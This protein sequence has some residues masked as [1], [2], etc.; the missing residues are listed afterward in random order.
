MV[1]VSMDID[2]LLNSLPNTALPN[3]ALPNIGDYNNKSD[4]LTIYQ[5]G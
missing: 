5:E 4:L 2:G 3:T 1:G